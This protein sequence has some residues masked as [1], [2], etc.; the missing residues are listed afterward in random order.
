MFAKEVLLDVL[1]GAHGNTALRK[2]VE[3][4]DFLPTIPDAMLSQYKAL[5]GTYATPIQYVDDLAAAETMRR[6]LGS[7]HTVGGGRCSRPSIAPGGY[8]AV[9]AAYFQ[10]HVEFLGL[11]P[12]GK[13]GPIGA[14][15]EI[16]VPDGVT[17]VEALATAA[18]V[19]VKDI[20]S[21]NGLT[22]GATLT[23]GQKLIV[24]GA[25]DHLV[26]ADAGLP[27]E[28]ATAET[29]DNIARMHGVTPA[30]LDRANP[31]VTTAGRWATLSQGQRILIPKH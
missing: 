31:G 9:K 17:T 28:T 13:E 23:P 25:R 10:G 1:P 15:D 26:V 6:K 3:T 5:I 12:E 2:A 8:N 11:D 20:L 18:N 24:R 4:D 22:A 21:A 14:P 30:Q 19:P 7:D 16:S 29:K 27:G